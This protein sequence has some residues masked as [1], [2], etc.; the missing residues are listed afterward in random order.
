MDDALYFIEH[1]RSEAYAS[2][3]YFTEENSGTFV[4]LSLEQ[5]SAN[6]L[7]EKERIEFDL[8]LDDVLLAFKVIDFDGDIQAFF[9][10]TDWNDVPELD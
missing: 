7:T 3:F 6:H 5:I 8:C 4:S 1:L 9:A 10:F 2:A